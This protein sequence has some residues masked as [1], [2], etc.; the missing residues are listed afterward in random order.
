MINIKKIISIITISLLCLTK[1]NAVIKDSIF[2]TIG[3]TAITKS[4]II[5]EVKIIL[6]ATG[7]SFSEDQ[8]DQIEKA[9]ILYFFW[10]CPEWTA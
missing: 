5:N 7:Q 9:E 10:P 3:D 2:A 6:I 1:G 8:R 4:D